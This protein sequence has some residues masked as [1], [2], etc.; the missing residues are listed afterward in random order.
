[1]RERRRRGPR[2][3]SRI[4]RPRARTRRRSPV[5]ARPSFPVASGEPEFVLER[6]LEQPATLDRDPAAAS[7]RASRVL[8]MR[9]VAPGSE[10]ITRHVPVSSGQGAAGDRVGATRRRRLL[11][12]GRDGRMAVSNRRQRRVR[13]FWQSTI[14][15]LALAVPRC[16]FP[17]G[18]EPPLLRPGDPGTLVV[19]DAPAGRDGGERVIDGDRPIPPVCPRWRRKLQGRFVAKMTPGLSTVEVRA[20]RRS[21]VRIHIGLSARSTAPF[22]FRHVVR[23]IGDARL[24]ASRHRRLAR[25]LPEL[26]RFVRG[27]VTAPR[28]VNADTHCAIRRRWMLPFAVCLSGEWWIRRRQGLR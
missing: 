12:S 28:T 27:A 5:R 17:I 9:V 16:R 1:M 2:W 7:L 15:G 25:P 26:E 13:S 24:I 21:P 19:R 11:L 18:I 20:T 22:V 8:V 4:A 3:I 14:A 10:V 23:R 6:L